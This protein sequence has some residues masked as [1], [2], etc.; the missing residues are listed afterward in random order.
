MILQFTV[1]RLHRSYLKVPFLNLMAQITERSG[2]VNVRVGGNS[3]DSAT[4]V[5]SL[6][7][8]VVLMKDKGNTTS[9]VGPAPF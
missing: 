5:D 9:P 2:H 3:Q 1:A 6:P 8:G 7:N 4:L